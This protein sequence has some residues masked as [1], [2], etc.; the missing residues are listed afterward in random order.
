MN[1]VTAS[2]Q[3]SISGVQSVICRADS[4]IMTKPM[5]IMMRGSTR[6]ASR[7]ATIMA[8]MV[9]MPRGA[10]RMPACATG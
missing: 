8:T 1:V 7:P 3:A 6:L 4:A 9:P 5:N 10:I 2:D